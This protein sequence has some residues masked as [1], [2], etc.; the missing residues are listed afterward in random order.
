MTPDM[1]PLVAPLVWEC[2]DWSSGDGVQGENDCEWTAEIWRYNSYIISWVGSG[3]FEVE[4]PTGE[5]IKADSLKAAKAAAQADYAARIIA[6]LDPAALA[7]MLAEARAN[8][9]REAADVDWS[10]GRDVLDVAPEYL[11]PWQRGLVA[12]QT[13]MRAAILALIDEEPQT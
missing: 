7:A 9:L 12:G 13:V 2:T 3:D 11:T 4:T 10:H 5:R 6:A 8:A 1:K